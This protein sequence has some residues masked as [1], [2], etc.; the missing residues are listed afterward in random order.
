[1]GCARWQLSKAFASLDLCK[2][3]KALIEIKKALGFLRGLSLLMLITFAQVAS[4]RCLN[5]NNRNYSFISARIFF[6]L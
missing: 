4:L 1:M 2:M 5:C 3:F 6:T